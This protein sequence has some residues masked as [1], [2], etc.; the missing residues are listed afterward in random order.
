MFKNLFPNKSREKEIKVGLKVSKL[1][2]V[3]QLALPTECITLSKDNKVVL[4]QLEDTNEIVLV[5]YIPEMGDVFYKKAFEY[6]VTNHSVNSQVLADKLR[7][8]FI[9]DEVEFT[10]NTE[11]KVIEGIEVLA[12]TKSIKEDTV[13]DNVTEINTNLL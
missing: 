4:T 8:I 3:T 10:L 7:D 9:I 5:K 11:V 13:I 6:N 2:K 12:L 1:K